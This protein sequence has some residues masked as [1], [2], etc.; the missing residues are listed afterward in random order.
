[1]KSQQTLPH[2]VLRTEK[3][4]LINTSFN[5][6]ELCKIGEGAEYNFIGVL[7]IKYA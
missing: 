5:R 7:Y 3:K 4:R 2:S 1:V 6:G